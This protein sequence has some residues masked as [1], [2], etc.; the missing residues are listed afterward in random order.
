MIELP[1]VYINVDSSLSTDDIITNAFT[2]WMEQIDMT[3]SNVYTDF[4][5]EMVKKQMRFIVESEGVTESTL[6]LPH[7]D[8]GG[9]K[10][11]FIA[12]LP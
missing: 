11:N 6:T 7:D 10:V 2:S 5:I 8:T 3:L 4:I 12:K 9:V 1:T